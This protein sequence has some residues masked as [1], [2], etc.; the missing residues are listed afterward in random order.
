MEPLPHYIKDSSDSQLLSI[1]PAPLH[2]VA[3]PE[4]KPRPLHLTPRK[5]Y[6]AC[7]ASASSFFEI[8]PPEL[9]DTIL[10]QLD[11]PSL[12]RLCATSTKAESYIKNAPYYKL[13]LEYGHAFLNTVREMEFLHILSAKG[14]YA[15]LCNP[16]CATPGCNRLV[17][18]VFVFTCQRYCGRCIGTTP[19]NRVIPALSFSSEHQT[20]VNT[21]QKMK[22]WGEVSEYVLEADFNEPA[23]RLPG[24]NPYTGGERQWWCST[25]CRVPL[26]YIDSET[27]MVEFARA[28][29]VCWC[30]LA[31]EGYAYSALCDPLTGSLPDR[32]EEARWRNKLQDLEYKACEWYGRKQLLHHIRSGECERAAWY[33]EHKRDALNF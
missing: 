33:W 13:I 17:G 24:G 3:E 16:T 7:I 27:D 5:Q 2:G 18:D 11:Y 28:C 15:A 25:F 29:R 32:E 20:I 6:S 8:L 26:A 31:D 23:S 22:S 10:M 1:I 12:S 14:V 30:V 9:L 19:M 21:L 4:T